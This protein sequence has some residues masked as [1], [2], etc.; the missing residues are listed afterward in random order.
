MTDFSDLMVATTAVVDPATTGADLALITKAQKRLWVLIASHPNAYPGLLDWLSTYGDDATKKAVAARP[1]AAA[2]DFAP[3]PVAPAFVPPPMAPAF[4][5]QPVAAAFV[6]PVTTPDSESYD[7][8]YAPPRPGRGRRVAVIAAIAVVVVVAIVLLAVRPWSSRT[9]PLTVDQF[10]YMLQNDAAVNLGPDYTDPTASDVGAKVEQDVP[11]AP[12]GSFF[13]V[14]PTCASQQNIDTAL[15]GFRAIAWIDNG[16]TNTTLVSG[17][18][19]FD[20]ADQAASIVKVA[21]LCYADSS[22]QASKSATIDGVSMWA[23][24]DTFDFGFAQYQNVFFFTNADNYSQKTWT[25]WTAQAPLLKRA[26]DVAAQ[27]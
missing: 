12:D 3:P 25:Q 14:D 10:V 1:P 9:T 19:L 13:G 7:Y 17:A 18:I 24:S 11:T 16:V 6:P 8:M 15:T 27:H 5:P 26:V 4:I 2:P 20:T 21:S 23:T 22:G